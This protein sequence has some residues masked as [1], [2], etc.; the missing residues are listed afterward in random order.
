[1]GRRGGEK[2]FSKKKRVV[3]FSRV[4]EVGSKYIF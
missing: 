3:E 4:K 2:I 1:M